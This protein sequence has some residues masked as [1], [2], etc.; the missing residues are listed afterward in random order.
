MAMRFGRGFVTRIDVAEREGVQ[1]PRF[2]V[3]FRV[4]ADLGGGG[5]ARGDLFRGSCPR[6]PERVDEMACW[7]DRAGDAAGAEFV[8]L[9][10]ELLA[11]RA[12]ADRW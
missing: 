1:R 5:A 4:A 3:A 12:L 7:P 8:W 11:G 9:R 2:A 6:G 10:A